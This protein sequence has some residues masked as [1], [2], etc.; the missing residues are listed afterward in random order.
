MRSVVR[1]RIG[2]GMCMRELS[3][4]LYL[5]HCDEIILW[6]PIKLFVG[7]CGVT[8]ESPNVTITARGKGAGNTHSCRTLEM[9]YKF[10]NGNA[11]SQT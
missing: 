9:F 3:T 7:F 11:V 1:V 8:H 6:F 5:T 10:Q 2:I 4:V